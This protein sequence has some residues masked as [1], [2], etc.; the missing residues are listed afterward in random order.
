MAPC[1]T[2]YTRLAREGKLFEKYNFKCSSSHIW[3]HDW[4]I[5]KCKF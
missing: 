2:K 3:M 4:T 5:Y 1:L